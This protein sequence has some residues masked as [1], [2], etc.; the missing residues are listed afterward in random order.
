MAACGTDSAYA[1]G[2]RCENCGAAHHKYQ[3]EYRARPGI[4]PRILANER[5]R[6]ARLSL[7]E[8][9][10]KWAASHRSR[11]KKE[12]GLTVAEYDEIRAGACMACGSTTRVVPDH[13]HKA[14]VVRGP[15]CDDCN[16]AL[17]RL[18]DDPIRV[19]AL[20][21]YIREW[22]GGFGRFQSRYA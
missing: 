8:R 14:G 21:A 13:D 7:E 12:F 3:I 2:C 1:L 17:G 9:A 22:A 18:G 4:M 6:Y 19:A 20:A 16:V 5:S 10:R 15:L 11:I